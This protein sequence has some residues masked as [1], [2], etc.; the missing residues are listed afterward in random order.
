MVDV[1]LKVV[2]VKLV[3]VFVYK[4]VEVLNGEIDD[5][6]FEGIVENVGFVLGALVVVFCSVKGLAEEDILKTM[7]VD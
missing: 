6:M 3:F 4:M 1:G 2:E 7:L 5:V